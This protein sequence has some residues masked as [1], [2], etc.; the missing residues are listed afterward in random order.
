MPVEYGIAIASAWFVAPKAWSLNAE[1]QSTQLWATIVLGGIAVIVTI[2]MA[3]RRQQPLSNR[4]AISACQL[5][6]SGLIVDQ[7][8]GRP[9]A[10]FLVYIS[11]AVLAFYRSLTVMTIA[12]VVTFA[13]FVFFAM[14]WPPSFMGGHLPWRL[15]EYSAWVVLEAA[16]LA[17]GI[18]QLRVEWRLHSDKLSQLDVDRHREIEAKVQKREAR[19]SLD[20]LRQY[21]ERTETIL[22]RAYEAFVAI[23]ESGQITDWNKQAENIFGWSKYE[24]I[25]QKLSEVIIPEAMRTAHE[26]GIRRFLQTGEG[27]ILNRSI[28]VSALHRSG[29]EFPVELSV[30]PVKL[31]EGWSFCAFLRD[32]TERTRLIEELALTRDKA[33]EASRLKSQF[34]ANMSH[35]IRTPMNGIIGMSNILL[36]TALDGKQFECASAI[37]DAG[38][39]LLNI[40]NGILDLSKI[41]AEKVEL[42]YRPFAALELIEGVGELLAPQAKA[43]N[44]SLVTFVDPEIPGELI[45]DRERLKQILMNLAGNAI[46]FSEQGQVIIRA[47]VDSEDNHTVVVR[48]SVTD[49]GIGI[50]QDE[51]KS[52]FQPFVQADGSISRKYGGT[53]LGL[54]ISKRLVELMEGKI[55]VESEKGKGSTFWLTLRFD[56]PGAVSRPIAS[57]QVLANLRVLIVDDEPYATD[58]LVSYLGSW[59]LR[60]V[61]VDSPASALEKLGAA[62][63]EG[64]PFQVAIVDLRPQLPEPCHAG[65]ELGRTI[66][67]DPRLRET[68]LILIHD[69]DDLRSTSEARQ[70]GFRA[71]LARPVKQS[72]LLDALAEIMAHQPSCRGGDGRITQEFA[73]RAKYAP[74]RRHEVVLIADDNPIN[75]QVIEFYLADMGFETHSVSDGRQAIEAISK[76]DYALVFLDCQMPELDGLEATRII[77][78]SE[79]G[80]SRHVPIVA[81]TAHAMKGDRDNCLAAGMDDYISKPI[82]ELEL[83][84]ILGRW[85]PAQGTSVSEPVSVCPESAESQIPENVEPDVS[86]LVAPQSPPDEIQTMVTRLLNLFGKEK[87]RRL[88]E[89]FVT[90]CTAALERLEQAVASA[91]AREVASTAHYLVGACGMMHA[92]TMQRLCLEVEQYVVLDNWEELKSTCQALA[93]SLEN[94]R[95]CV[96][97]CMAQD[98]R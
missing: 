66:R 77:R 46:K 11:F 71:L 84:E 82:D 64:D 8:G 51:V 3:G 55:G 76:A 53:G 1:Q 52:L 6:M 18:R 63:Q 27:A 30:T 35:E 31:G 94:L 37:H 28:Q 59:G 15:L 17:Y 14:N 81:M 50:S 95:L 57:R 96:N 90:D 23:N 73:L 78:Q 72:Q 97:E 9:E 85:I 44:L 12:M 54:S 39:S 13:D 88:L 74:A 33:Q 25:G 47:T 24:V 61:R 45:G 7:F 32:I 29:H 62:V 10:F 79:A 49:S 68:K 92:T 83:R 21:E 34:V 87:T 36:K 86:K 69:V 89:V 42:E 58:V 20:Q 70:A 38:K 91:N 40:I 65:L 67:D 98:D 60:S 93:N 5:L 19:R 2:I 26:A 56:R 4:Y 22:E 16:L 43:K 75:R 41:E 80:C 48:I